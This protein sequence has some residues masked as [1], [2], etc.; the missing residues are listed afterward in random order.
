MSALSNFTYPEMKSVAKRSRQDC[1][2]G[3]NCPRQSRGNEQVREFSGGGLR[4]QG[5][6]CESL[7][8]NLCVTSPAGNG[9]KSAL[10]AGFKKDI[11]HV[12]HRRENQFN[13]ENHRAGRTAAGRRSIGRRPFRSSGRAHHSQTEFG[14]RTRSPLQEIL[15]LTGWILLYYAIF[16][17]PEGGSLLSSVTIQPGHEQIDIAPGHSLMEASRERFSQAGNAAGTGARMVLTSATEKRS[18]EALARQI[19]YLELAAH[20]DSDIFFTGVEISP[21]GALF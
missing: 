2:T 6:G 11:V 1:E 20:P 15:R 14:N 7:Q 13:P 12:H 10:T 21:A 16:C 9:R 18:A 5:C 17:F 8:A 3:Q 19:H 4:G